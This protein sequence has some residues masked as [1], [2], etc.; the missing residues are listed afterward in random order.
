MTLV[1][2]AKK[3]KVSFFAYIYDRVSGAMALP[4]LAELIKQ[5]SPA[6]HPVTT[7]L[8]A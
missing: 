1:A 7:D 5:R 6:F 8:S 3:L 2:T 4:S